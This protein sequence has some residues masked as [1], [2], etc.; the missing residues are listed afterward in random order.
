MNNSRIISVTAMQA[1][2]DEDKPAVEVIIQTENGAVGKASVFQALPD[3]R[4]NPNYL[5]D[6][7]LEYN[8][9]GVKT[10]AG[11]I[12][13]IVG[14]AIIGLP[15]D[16]QGLI[17]AA[18]KKSLNDVN[19]PCYVNISAPVSIAALKAGAQSKGLPLY[20]HIGGRAA[21]VL[22]VAGQLAASGSKRYNLDSH[23]NGKP[24]YLLTAYGFDSFEE[25]HYAL[26]ETANAYE[27]LLSKR[28]HLL[29][30]RGFSLA[31]PAE[32]IDHDRKLWEIMAEAIEKAGYTGKIG[33]QADIGANDYYDADSG[34]YKGLFSAEDK[35]RD[36]LITLYN[37]MAKNYPFV[38]LLD[39]LE[40][41][42]LDGYA[43]VLEETGIQIVGRD[44]CGTDFERIK[45]C[46]DHGGINSVLLSVCSFA[47]F[48]DAIKVVRY[49]KNHGVDVMPQN[50][51]GEDMDL[52]DYA[53]GFSVGTIYESGLEVVGN[54]LLAI[55]HE[56]GP[57]SRFYGVGGLQGSKFN[58]V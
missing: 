15:A 58:L 39:P 31:V 7:T 25:S 3:G 18:I 53:V 33:I 43:K 36:D 32:K 52:A 41:N 46:I 30:H 57:R 10:A 21:F 37:E 34:L 20:R 29:V 26:W 9:F 19:I 22:P 50:L 48:S 44:I 27:K 8:G 5:Y 4:W 40:E 28:Y 14:P 38:T 42:D 16:C 24:V 45:I 2:T 12:N 17:D 51:A 13:G 47:T 55:E 23:S 54:S 56:I 1:S 35:T 11:I 49:A 6:N